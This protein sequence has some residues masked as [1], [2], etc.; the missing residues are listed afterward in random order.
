M[1]VSDATR[2]HLDLLCR[3]LIR[4]FALGV[5]VMVFWA[6]V[7]WLGRGMVIAI[8]GPAF[9]ITERDFALMAYASMGILKIVLLTVFLFPYIAIRWV[10]ARTPSPS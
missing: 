4:C 6:L 8:H 5:A 7:A 10:L 1:D 3:I 9:G 2:A